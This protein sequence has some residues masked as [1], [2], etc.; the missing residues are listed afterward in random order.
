MRSYPVRQVIDPQAPSIQ[1]SLDLQRREFIRDYPDLPS[2]GIRRCAGIAQSDYFRRGLGFISVAK[3]ASRALTALGHLMVV[4]TGFHRIIG[5][6]DDP[7]A[8][9]WISS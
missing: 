9:Y 7:P 5:I 4:I 8:A 3:R 2:R 1:L 6:H